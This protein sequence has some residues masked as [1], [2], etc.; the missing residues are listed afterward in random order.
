MHFIHEVVRVIDEVDAVNDGLVAFH[1]DS[2]SVSATTEAIESI[3][4]SL[5]QGDRSNRVSQL[6][7][8]IVVG[9]GHNS[10]LWAVSTVEQHSDIGRSNVHV[11]IEAVRPDGLALTRQSQPVE[12]VAITATARNTFEGDLVDEVTVFTTVDAAI[13][14]IV[15]T[16]GMR[17]SAHAE[18]TV[19]PA[20]GTTLTILFH[21]VD[22]EYTIVVGH[23]FRRDTAVEVD[24]TIGNELDS[25]IDV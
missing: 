21:T 25:G 16:E 2:D 22:V 23:A 3:E 11:L 13:L 10:T 7:S 14:T 17:T 19:G 20:G 5:I 18:V 4:A 1:F 12:V 15:P 24:R 9:E 6:L 8:F